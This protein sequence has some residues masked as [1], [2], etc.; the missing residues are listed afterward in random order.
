MRAQMHRVV[1]SLL[2]LV[3]LLGSMKPMSNVISSSLVP[4]RQDLLQGYTG[5]G[6]SCERLCLT[7]I[8]RVAS[9]NESL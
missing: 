7:R 2:S 9:S 5:H 6:R 4:A 1:E 3:A 8:P